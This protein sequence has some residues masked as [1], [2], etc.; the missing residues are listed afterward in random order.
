M[1]LGEQLESELPAELTPWPEP[2]AAE[3]QVAAKNPIPTVQD[4]LEDGGIRE[5]HKEFLDFVDRQREAE[6]ELEILTLE[7]KEQ[8]LY[9][10]PDL[11]SEPE[12]PKTEFQAERLLLNSLGLL[13][14]GH[15]AE[16]DSS[17]EG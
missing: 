4:I 15:L 8:Q 14:A 11:I 10:D 9:P 12:L 5:Q 13:Q 1:L 2:D 7:K 6:R 3:A 17:K 16:M